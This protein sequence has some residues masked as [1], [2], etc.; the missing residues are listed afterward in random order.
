MTRSEPSGFDTARDD[1]VLD[2][3]SEIASGEHDDA[4]GRAPNF[5][6]RRAIVIGGVVAA[7]V[8]GGLVVNALVRNGGGDDA[9]GANVEWNTIALVDERSGDVILT[10]A[11][12]AE[13]SRFPSGVRAAVDATTLGPT[14]MVTSSDAVA[15]IDL[16][17]ETAQSFDIAGSEPGVVTP[18]G[19]NDV[20]LAANAGRDRMVLAHRPT[21]D[22]LDTAAF[23]PIAGAQFDTDTPIATPDGRSVLVTD[24]GNFQSVLLSFDSDE[25]TFFTGRALALDDDVVVTTQNVGNEASINVFGHDGATVTTTRAPSVR[26]GMVSGDNV[27][28]VTV[29]GEIIE[30]ATSSGTTSSLG[31]VDVGPIQSG[32]V[33]PLGDRLVVVGDGGTAIVDPD[34]EVVGDFDAASPIAGSAGEAAPRTSTCLALSRATDGTVLVANLNDGSIVEEAEVRGSLESS[35]DGCAVVASVPTAITIVS[36]AGV[37]R[38]LVDGEF[39][40][41]APDAGSVIIESQNRL[42]LIDIADA[43]SSESSPDPSPPDES[44]PD[45]SV[46]DGAGGSGADI[47]PSSRIVGY[48]EL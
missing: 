21:G 1:R 11:T 31:T 8:G 35:A 36:A 14:L 12:G 47:G 41:I 7:I 44:G 19:S 32:F 18:S 37:E 16:T 30:L 17:S 39:V 38:I 10:D 43:G 45:D 26:A 33:T 40:A 48:T 22:V 25:P 5:L 42:V 13:Q 15:V 23:A 3:R 28:L 34:G 9:I 24:T 6:I 2:D 46:P 29:D 20:M 27:L 4:P